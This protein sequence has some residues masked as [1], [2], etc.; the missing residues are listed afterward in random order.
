[1]TLPYTPPLTQRP[2]LLEGLAAAGQAYGGLGTPAA[3]L[4][5]QIQAGQT[6]FQRALMYMQM[7]RQAEL[8]Q[9]LVGHRNALD[10]AAQQR[11]QGQLDRLQETGR[12]NTEMEDTRRQALLF[13]RG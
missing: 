8:M 11:I 2:G 4:Q 12:H 10:E 5:G 6:E 7:Q 9:S 3:G 1:M 13:L